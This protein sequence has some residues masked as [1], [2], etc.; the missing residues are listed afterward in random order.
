M[1]LSLD[2]SFK[3]QIHQTDHICYCGLR[4]TAFAILA[5]SVKHKFVL[6]KSIRAQRAGWTADKIPAC[7]ELL[8]QK[9]KLFAVSTYLKI[10]A[11]Q[12]KVNKQARMSYNSRFR[13]RAVP[14]FLSANDN[15]WNSLGGTSPRI[16]NPMDN[17]FLV[18]AQRSWETIS[19]NNFFGSVKIQGYPR[20]FLLMYKNMLLKIL[21]N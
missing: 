4:Q 2:W 16:S 5:T 15:K 6:S 11:N 13:C 8:K 12:Q 7:S 14:S 9:R 20:L 21:L 10:T 19:N 18:R 17:H 3:R 1:G